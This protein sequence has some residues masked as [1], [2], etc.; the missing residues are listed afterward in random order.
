MALV[1]PR[2]PFLQYVKRSSQTRAIFFKPERKFRFHLFSAL[3]WRSC[4]QECLFFSMLSLRWRS[5]PHECLF[6]SMLSTRHR[7]EL[8]FLNPKENPTFIF[9]LQN[10][11]T[12][13]RS[14]MALVSPRVPFSFLHNAKALVTD[15]RYLF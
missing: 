5:C 4:P 10:L 6:F 9:F 13:D 14:S 8:S 15:E 7:R 11:P 3:R 2:V 1:S 12:I